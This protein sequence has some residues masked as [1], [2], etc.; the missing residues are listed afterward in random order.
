MDFAVV[1]RLYPKEAREAGIFGR[2]F[3]KCRALSRNRVRDCSIVAESPAGMGFGAAAL[4]A[5]RSYRVKIRDQS[6]DQ[7]YG[8]WMIIEI[9]YDVTE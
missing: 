7:V 1:K 9:A 6:G 8:R 2:A 5:Q 3:L 4:K